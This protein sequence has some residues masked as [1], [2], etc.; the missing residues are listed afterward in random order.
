MRGARRHPQR[1]SDPRERDGKGHLP[2]RRPKQAKESN[3][4]ASRTAGSLPK[5]SSLRRSAGGVAGVPARHRS[6]PGG[7]I[8]VL[9]AGASTY[10]RPPSDGR[11]SFESKTGA[12]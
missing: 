11:L 5:S 8:R 6:A 10:D 3:Q 1:H 4:A 9:D 12:G 2:S 7:I